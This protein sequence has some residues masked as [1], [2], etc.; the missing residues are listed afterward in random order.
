MQNI[1][2]VLRQVIRE[3]LNYALKGEVPPEPKAIHC[4]VQC[5]NCNVAPITGT[6][7]K[8]QSECPNFDLCETCMQTVGHDHQMIEMATP[9]DACLR[10]D[11]PINN[12]EG[13]N[14]RQFTKR[15]G[16]LRKPKFDVVDQNQFAACVHV[17]DQLTKTWTI[18]NKSQ[19][20]IPAGTIVQL[21]RGNSPDYEPTTITEDI[22]PDTTAEFCATFTVPEGEGKSA[23]VFKLVHPDGFRFGPRLKANI[24]V[25]SA[26]DL[27]E[28]L[29]ETYELLLTMGFTP[30]AAREKVVET[31][32][33]IGMAVSIL[34]KQ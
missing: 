31:N 21:V 19:L 25:A 13:F 27:P 12:T 11:I 28:H 29:R 15:F 16:K 8:C 33:D 32:G 6:R 9:Q 2:S 4:R 26:D 34:T 5:D 1:T 23:I 22:A 17:G 30:E 7:F 20:P 24:S 14:W 3:E 10:M 18:Y